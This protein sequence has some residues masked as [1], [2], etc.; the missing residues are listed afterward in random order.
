M[1]M[2]YKHPTAKTLP[3]HC[4]IKCPS[5]IFYSLVTLRECNFGFLLFHWIIA[6]WFWRFWEIRASWYI[7]TL[8]AVGIPYRSGRQKYGHTFV[9]GTR[10]T[11][12]NA[13]MHVPSERSH[14]RFAA[15]PTHWR[16]IQMTNGYFKNKDLNERLIRTYN[17]RYHMAF[18][19]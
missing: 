9:F 13:R 7:A 19:V 17:P 1:Y 2:T 5:S 11:T 18:I 14:L 3:I 10:S 15:R 8:E 6:H 12:C 4:Q 16:A